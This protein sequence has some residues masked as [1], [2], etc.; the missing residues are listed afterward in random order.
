MEVDGVDVG[1]KAKRATGGFTF[2]RLVG[3]E[4]FV[5]KFWA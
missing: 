5:N 4:G 1:E 2:R 3:S